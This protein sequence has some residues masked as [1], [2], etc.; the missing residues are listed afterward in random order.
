MPPLV[1][2]QARLAMIFQF[3]KQ[4][5]VDLAAIRPKDISRTGSGTSRSRCRPSRARCG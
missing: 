4:Y 5:Y 2:S 3:E 1:L